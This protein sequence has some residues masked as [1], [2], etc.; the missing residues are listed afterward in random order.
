MSEHSSFS[1]DSSGYPTP[2]S[3]IYITPD[4]S[5]AS[6]SASL[7]S[8]IDIPPATPSHDSALSSI[9]GEGSDSD[10]D[11]DGDAE[12]EWQESLRQL[13]MLISMVAVPFLGKWIGRRTAY[14]AWAKFMGWKYPIDVVIANRKALNIAGAV[15]VSAVL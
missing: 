9:S 6:L 3:S 15:A 10:D 7:P 13:E 1:S 11:D 2:E 14:W 5:I 8:I 4:A 12:E